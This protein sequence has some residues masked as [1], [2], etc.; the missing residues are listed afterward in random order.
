MEGNEQQRRRKALDARAKGR[1]PSQDAGTTGSSKQR[2]HLHADE[3][4]LEKLGTIHHGKQPD[5]GHH[6]ARPD[7]RPHSGP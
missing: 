4:H 2:H 7:P 5:A 3:N 6:V 1:L